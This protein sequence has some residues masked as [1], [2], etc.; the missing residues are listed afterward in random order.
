[1]RKSYK[2]VRELA[3]SDINNS[4]S[5]AI[6]SVYGKSRVAPIEWLKDINSALRFAHMCD[7]ISYYEYKYLEGAISAI[8]W[9]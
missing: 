2:M 8:I 1:M 3:E 9:E 7:I 6:D 4:F 5:C